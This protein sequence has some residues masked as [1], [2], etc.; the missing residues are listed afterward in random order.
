MDLLAEASALALDP[1]RENAYVGMSLLY[2]HTA[3]P[4][5]LKQSFTGVLPDYRGKGIALAMKLAGIERARAMGYREIRTENDS[6]NAPMLRI[7]EALG[8]QREAARL[9]FERR[10]AGLPDPVDES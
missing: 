6:L 10:L 7:N 9:T 4:D 5:V 2:K 3:L 1:A 8:F